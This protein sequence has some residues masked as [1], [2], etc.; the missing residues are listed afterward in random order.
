MTARPW[1]IVFSF[2]LVLLLPFASAAPPLP[3][4]SSAQIP[5]ISEEWAASW[6]AKQIDHTLELY[7]PD[8]AFLTAEGGRV[9]GKAAIRK[10]FQQALDSADP[11]ITFH[12]VSSSTSGDLA[13]DSGEYEEILTFTGRAPAVVPT[14]KPVPQAGTTMKFRGNYLIVFQRQPGGRWLIE[15]HMWTGAPQASK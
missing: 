8:A 1:G 13:F 12:S 14:D 7:A 11:A 5:Q 15:Q 6:N 9:S 2:S 4:Q 10:L 3:A